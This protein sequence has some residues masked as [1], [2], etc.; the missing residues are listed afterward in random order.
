[1][2]I[3]LPHVVILGA[4]ASRAAFAEGD[5]N[6]S[7]LPLMIDLVETVGVND[8]LKSSGIKYEGR[9]FE[10][11]Y[12]DMCRNP[13][14]QSVV[15]EINE[16]IYE[17]FYRL[18]LPANIT[19]YDRLV[20]SLRGKDAIATFNWDPLL[21]F[22]Y[23]RN[24]HMGDLP[25]VVSLHGNV[26]VGIC[27]KDKVKG[28]NGTSCAICGD[29]LQPTNLLYPIKQKNYA[30]DP[31]LKNEWIELEGHLK[32]AYFLTI[33]GY[34]AP[35]ADNEAINLI[36][37]KWDENKYKDIAEIEIID[38]KSSPDLENSWRRLIVRQHFGTMNDYRFSHLSRHPRR[39]C[40]ALFQAT[41]LND[42]WQDNFP[43]ENTTL[44]E[45]QDWIQPLILEEQD[46]EKDRFC[47][48]PCEKLK[49]RYH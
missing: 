46:T 36:Q 25:R 1:M 5:I 22:A 43:P 20:L 28:I 41:I 27:V 26:A 6:G 38:I 3:G 33:Y 8:L 18:R 44:E 34:S 23:R 19:I 17:Y 40:E 2:K 13:S 4:G 7:K 24:S 37:K 29:R 48:L 10:D 21:A 49:E 12:D 31:F 42:P 11:L 45:F 32:S 30:D 47:G 9:N 35:I 15:E 16:R 39:S 14:L